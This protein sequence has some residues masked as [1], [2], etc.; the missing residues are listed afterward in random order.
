MC[1]ANMGK[2]APLRSSGR[3]HLEQS[4]KDIGGLASDDKQPRVQLPEA[5]VQ[6]LETLQ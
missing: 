1:L 2:S 3:F 5:G 6:V 4:G